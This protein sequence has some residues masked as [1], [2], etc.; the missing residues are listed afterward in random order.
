MYALFIEVTAGE[1]HKERAREMLNRVR[2]ARRSGRWC[3]FRR[4]ART[5]ERPGRIPSPGMR[6]KKRLAT[7]A[8]GFAVGQ[9]PFDDAPESVTIKTVEVR[10]VIASL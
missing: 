2:S 1:E 6:R 10:E 7:R 3:D 4:L 8:K 5:H 9:R